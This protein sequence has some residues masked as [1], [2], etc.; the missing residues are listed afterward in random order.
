MPLLLADVLFH[1]FQV[2]ARQVEELQA[3]NQELRADIWAKEEHIAAK[4]RQVVT[5]EG[6]ISAKERQVLTMEGEIS[7]KERQVVTMEGE[8]SA[9]ERQVVTMEGEISAKERQVVIMEGEILA[10]ER[11]VVTKERHIQQQQQDMAAKSE[12][13]QQ[14]QNTIQTLETQ[15]EVSID[16]HG[17]LLHNRY[18]ASHQNGKVSFLLFT[19][20][21]SP[22]SISMCGKISKLLV[23][24]PLCCGQ[25][26]YSTSCVGGAYL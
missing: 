17:Y 12:L 24:Y 7:A 1:L 26:N 18:C 5:M 14:L 3:D 4:E 23:K 15:K 20:L 22:R 8:I 10:K 9:K 21:S 6:E 11:E 16:L 13:I 25:L 2:R 19:F